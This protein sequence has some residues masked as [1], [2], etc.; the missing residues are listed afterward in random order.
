[1][2]SSSVWKHFLN[3]RFGA[4]R[5]IYCHGVGAMHQ[6]DTSNEL[7]QPYQ[8]ASWSPRQQARRNFNCIDQGQADKDKHYGDVPGA[9]KNIDS[10][11]AEKQ[12][13]YRHPTIRLGAG[14][15][16]SPVGHREPVNAVSRERKA[17]HV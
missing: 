12:E 1:M 7:E 2:Q 8:A 3:P 6:P 17:R 9:P 11:D 13:G 4:H 10:E 5:Q 14:I 16:I 15:D